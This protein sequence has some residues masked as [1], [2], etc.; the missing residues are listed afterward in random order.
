MRGRERHQPHDENT[1]LLNDEVPI[2]PTG[3]VDQHVG[4][5]WQKRQNRAGHRAPI[6][7]HRREPQLQRR[8]NGRDSGSAHAHGALPRH[9]R[10]DQRDSRAHGT[11]GARR[12]GAGKRDR[13][14]HDP[15]DNPRHSRGRPDTKQPVLTAPGRRLIFANATIVGQAEED[16]P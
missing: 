3:D 5:D 13:R 8:W 10:P 12:V 1:E 7:D 16:G 11:S 15:V 4:G 14:E 6:P 2:E 9:S